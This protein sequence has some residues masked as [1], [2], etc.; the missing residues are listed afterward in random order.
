MVNLKTIYKNYSLIIIA[1]FLLQLSCTSDVFDNKNDLADRF[2][3]DFGQNQNHIE[4][5]QYKAR[6]IDSLISGNIRDYSGI[7]TLGRDP[8]D[9]LMEISFL[10]KRDSSNWMDH[11]AR[12]T[13][14]EVATLFKAYRKEK[15]YHDLVLGTPGGQL[16]IRDLL[17]LGI[18][19]Y[20]IEDFI[21]KNYS[22]KHSLT[23]LRLRIKRI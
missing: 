12:N 4:F 7:V 20:K 16:V 17:N 18:E 21:T 11:Y 22:R 3:E 13:Y 19:G 15:N 8:G 1:S 5:I 14:Y 6:R 23:A 2:L 9:S 10:A